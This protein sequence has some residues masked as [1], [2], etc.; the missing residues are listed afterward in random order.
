MY[1]CPKIYTQRAFKLISDALRPQ[2]NKWVFRARLKRYQSK[3]RIR[4]PII[5]SNWYTS[6]HR[7]P[8]IA[9]FLQPTSVV[10]TVLDA[11]A[12]L[13]FHTKRHGKPTSR[14][15]SDAAVAAK[16]K[17]RQLRPKWCWKRLVGPCL[18]LTHLLGVN[19]WTTTT[20]FGFKKETRNLALLY[21]WN[22]WIFRTFWTV[23]ECDRQTDGQNGR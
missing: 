9:S 13:K 3:S 14:Y 4:H 7:F 1:V 11:L 20:K 21:V 16:Q 22:T 15:L 12:P 19:P 5:G 23:Y 2:T 8:V 18:S 17:R 6:L 10:T